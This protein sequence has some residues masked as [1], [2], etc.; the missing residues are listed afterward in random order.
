MI[1][2]SKNAGADSFLAKP[3]KPSDLKGRLVQLSLARNASVTPE[4]AAGEAAAGGEPAEGAEPG[5][6]AGQTGAQEDENG[7]SVDLTSRVKSIEGLPSFPATHAEILKLA[8]SEDA[9][10]DDIAEKLQL[11]SGLLATIFKLV[12]SSGYGFRKKVDS[13]KLAVTLLGLEEIA[14]LVMAAQVFDKLGNYE[15]GSGM[16]AT[17]FWRHSIG[18]GFAAR[19]ISKKLQTEAESAFLAG[20]LHNVGKIVLDR[21]F[22]DYYKEVLAIV[23]D[24][25]TLIVDAEKEVLGVTHADIGG[26][27]ATEWK[28]ANNYLNRILYHHRP[29]E[30]ARYKRLVCLIHIADGITRELG[31]GSGGDSVVPEIQHAAL[32]QFH[33]ADRGYQMLKDSVEEE[34]EGADSFLAALNS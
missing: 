13:L 8:N 24:G 29:G 23:E 3:F 12:N 1:I 34:L 4:A 33:M 6:S 9:T 22:V 10:S 14:N 31:F 21:F 25:T 15:D 17:E 11:D 30:A 28:F 2:R 26:V 5:V 16:D 19:A 20:M 18:V 32:D 27:L 7:L